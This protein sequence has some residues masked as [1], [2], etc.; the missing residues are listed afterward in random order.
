MSEMRLPVDYPIDTR[1]D[2]EM[3]DRLARLETYN[4]H[5]YRPNSYLHKWWARRCG[6]TFRFILKH[7]VTDP[8]QQDFYVP[9]GLEGKIILDPMIGGG[10][11]LHEAI[12]M[13]A[14][15]IGMDLDPIPVLQARAALTEHPLP[16]IEEAFANLYAFLRASLIQF[17]QTSCPHCA[18]PAESWYTL[19]GAR[20][21]CNCGE[22][23]VVDSLIIRQEPDGSL[24]RICP[25]CR[26]LLSGD[27]AC[28]CDGIAEVQIIE[29]GV[30]ECSRCQGEY[31]ENLEIPYFQRYTPLVVT[32]HCAIHGLFLRAPDERA[33]S[34]MKKA[35]EQ[36][37]AVALD[38]E[39]FKVDAGRKSVQLL[40]RGIDNYLDLYSS[41]QLL[42][43]QKGTELMVHYTGTVKLNLALLLST[44]LE[45]NSLLS[46]YKGKS[47]RRPGAIRH[48][49]AHHAYSFPYTALENNPLYHRRASGTLQKLFQA[50]IRRGRSWAAMPRE[51]DVSGSEARY[52]DIV[53]E[54]DGGVETKSLDDLRTG[55]RRFLLSQ[56]SA[57]QIDLPEDSVDAIVTDPPYFDSVQ[58][59]DLSAFFRVWLRQMLPQEANWEFGLHDS[60]VDPHKLDRESRY[61]E[62][63][64]QIF[65]E[66]YRVLRKEDGRLVLTF[67][68]WNPKGWS[69]LTNALKDA[70][71]T[72]LNRAVVHSES[73]ISVHIAG[74]NALTHDAILVLAPRS[75]H[76]RERWDKPKQISRVSS[77]QFCGDCAALLGWMLD[78]GLWGADIDQMWR[79]ELS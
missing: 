63:M 77:A 35:H 25:F 56:G 51:R 22:V 12:R 44:S 41:R 68:H 31:R 54:V 36:R 74:M 67:H 5:Y 23:L 73:P 4:K 13:G 50:R 9:G 21:Y 34:G 2:V 3:A 33:L 48:A 18:E 27:A 39:A 15:V 8:R 38:R 1:F 16:E 58:Y 64:G 62:L 52:V 47:K 75:E 65:A 69:A 60:A 66:C 28:G 17:F 71:F 57:T 37:Q 46:G 42:V 30:R 14:N 72:L 19:H 26:K 79:D 49:F 29:R 11:T 59:S 24:T 55:K 20:R 70:G 32:G 6:T 40:R 45:F 76:G 61:A 7:L 78:S 10:T 53:G 43:F